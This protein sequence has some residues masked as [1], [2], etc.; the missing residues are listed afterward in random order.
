[1]TQICYDKLFLQISKEF[2]CRFYMVRI[3]D[4]CGGR[5]AAFAGRFVWSL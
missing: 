4:S 2:R 1:M 3:S 5:W